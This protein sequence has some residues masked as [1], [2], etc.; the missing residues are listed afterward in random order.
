MGYPDKIIIIKI[1]ISV[2]HRDGQPLSFILCQMN[3]K[4]KLR[5]AVINISTYNV[6][7]C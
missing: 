3:E 4:K 2:Q 5:C 7:T 6:S 1:I